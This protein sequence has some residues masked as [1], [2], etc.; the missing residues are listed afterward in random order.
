MGLSR[1]LGN[2]QKLVLIFYDHQVKINGANEDMIIAA[3]EQF[4]DKS[5]DEV[6]L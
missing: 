1:I 5:D 2:P 3:C 6:F 4:G